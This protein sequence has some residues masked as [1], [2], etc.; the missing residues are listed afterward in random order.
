MK[1]D[2]MSK[3]LKFVAPLALSCFLAAGCGDDDG[4]TPQADASQSQ[5]DAM[6]QD[7]ADAMVQGG[8]TLGVVC[9]VANPTECGT[10]APACVFF[11]NGATTGF[12]SKDCGTVPDTGDNP[13]TSAPTG[14]D[15]IC[16][17]DYSNEGTPACVLFDGMM[18]DGSGEVPFSCGILCGMAGGMNF[19]NCPTGL[20]CGGNNLC[21][22]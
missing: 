17:Q 9:T 16:Q 5:A 8:S 10:D 15:A 2:G 3:Y 7:Q 4:G 21:A 22:P 13:P 19:G 18:I 20:T 14:G 11:E 6:V 1:G 12:C